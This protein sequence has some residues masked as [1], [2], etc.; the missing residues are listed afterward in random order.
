MFVLGAHL[1]STYS[2]MPYVDYAQE[3]IFDPLNM[4]ST[5]FS[6]NKAFESGKRSESWAEDGHFIPF[7]FTEDM[8]ELNAGQGGIISNVDDM[9]C[10]SF[11]FNVVL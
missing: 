4:T 9:V 5:T 7:W 6:P 1:I 10:T 3:R 11:P 8:I 2:G